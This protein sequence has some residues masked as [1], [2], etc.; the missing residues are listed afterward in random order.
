MSHMPTE[1]TEADIIEFFSPLNPE[2]M[3]IL[4]DREDKPMGKAHV[5][6]ATHEECVKAMAKDQ[7]EMGG[8]QVNLYLNSTDGT[9]SDHKSSQR[10]KNEDNWDCKCGYNNYPT[11]SNCKSCGEKKRS[12]IPEHRIGMSHLS[13]DT[14]EADIREFFSPH[15]PES[16]VLLTDRD[17]NPMGKAHAYFATHDA[18]VAAMAKDQV[19]MGTWKV[20]LYLNS[21]DGTN[22]QQNMGV[23]QG[24]TSANFNRGDNWECNCSYSNFANKKLCFSC[25]ESK[26]ASVVEHRI[27]MSHLAYECKE[28]DLKQFFS[29]LEAVSMKILH[30]SEGNPMG[31]AN[32]YFSTHAECLQAMEKDQQDVCGYRVNLYLNSTD[33]TQT[34]KKKKQVQQNKIQFDV[35]SVDKSIN[36]T[37]EAENSKKKFKWDKFIRGCLKSSDN[38]QLTLKKL[39]KAYK[40]QGEEEFSKEEFKEKL[41]QRLGKSSK[42]TYQNGIVALS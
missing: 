2:S 28:D 3:T 6:F 8:Q 23:K 36:N 24:D 5:Y 20:N 12:T 39:R 35:S 41:E 22:P 37:E 19:D 40:N 7:T 42:F 9:G 16:I 18:C 11:R 38:N 27:G 14:T 32:V 4:T 13:F 17:G 15:E 10:G 33:E 30:D 26:S 25:G 1:S 31:K 34:P 21:T 29:P